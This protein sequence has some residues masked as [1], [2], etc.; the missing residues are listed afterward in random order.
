MSSLSW[1]PGPPIAAGREVGSL[2]YGSFGE[3]KLSLLCQGLGISGRLRKQADHV[4]RLMARS[5][6]DW[7]LGAV[8][9]WPNDITDD[10]TPFE[11][12]VAFDGGAPKLRMLVESQDASKTLLSSWRAGLRLN[13]RLRESENVD[14]E[15]FDRVRDLFSPSAE[16]PPRY[17]LWHAAV[18]DD[19]AP[20]AYK[21]YLNPQ[22]HGSSGARG[23]VLEALARLD[24]THASDFLSRAAIRRQ[25]PGHF[26]YFSLD[27]SAGPG[28]RVKVYTAHRGANAD[29]IERS[30]EGTRNLV[31]GEARRWI[32]ETLGTTGPFQ[33]R[34]ILTC[35]AFTS[36]N[37][38]PAATVHLPIRCYTTDDEGAMLRAMQYLSV[39]DGERLRAALC[40]V[41]DRALKSGR[42]LLTYLS[43]R[44]SGSGV[45]VTAYI[46]PEAFA[47]TPPRLAWPPRPSPLGLAGGRGGTR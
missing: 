29:D 39:E 42:G 17:A 7:P 11:F 22:V 35:L 6:A 10:G 2:S 12:S 5:W 47:V 33:S 3:R 45:S 43:L 9:E 44:R 21:V 46:A 28:A 25:E 37:D 23:V 13:E 16:A 40:L 24:M 19:G 34:P 15:R 1:R 4:F 36:S 14:L 26:L 27:L 30:L 41:G 20:A 8:P 31:P 32:E 38:P 18:L